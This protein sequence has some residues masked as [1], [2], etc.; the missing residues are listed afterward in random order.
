MKKGY[1]ERIV[2]AD[3]VSLHLDS[4]A[5]TWCLCDLNRL[6]RYD[7]A[8]YLMYRNGPMKN[9]EQASFLLLRVQWIYS[10]MSYS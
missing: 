6:E 5:E 8:V 1:N 2:S 7:E 9:L 4:Y 3:C 10:F